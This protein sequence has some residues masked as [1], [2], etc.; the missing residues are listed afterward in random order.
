MDEEHLRG[1]R[2]RIR[3]G[4][5]RC[6]CSLCRTLDGVPTPVEEGRRATIEARPVGAKLPGGAGTRYSPSQPGPALIPMPLERIRALAEGGL[7][8]K[9][10]RRVLQAE[11]HDVSLRTLARRVGELRQGRLE[12]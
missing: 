9:A 10:I 12:L 2:E 5:D 3:L 6:G 8:V 4:L 11:G 7:G 1:E